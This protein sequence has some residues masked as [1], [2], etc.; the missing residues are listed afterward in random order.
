MATAHNNYYD[1][2]G[3]ATD[4]NL[5][6]VK[7]ALGRLRKK[8]SAGG[9]SATLNRIESILV[10]P[11]KR[12]KYDAQL[13]QSDDAFFAATELT[14]ADDAFVDLGEDAFM[15][16]SDLYLQQSDIEYA[17]SQDTSEQDIKFPVDTISLVK[18]VASG[19]LVA[20]LLV[21]A[22]IGFVRYQVH[23]QAVGAIAQ[24]E[25]AQA[26]VEQQIR[27]NGYFPS[28]LTGSV[29]QSEFYSL[30]LEQQKIVL[31]F[32]DNAAG[33]I[34]GSELYLQ[35]KHIPQLGLNWE[36]NAGAGFEQ[37]YLPAHCY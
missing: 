18:K 2:L 35:A 25:V 17:M 5:Q 10:D 34:R 22:Y 29:A 7:E 36:C 8:D 37:R 3:I 30:R 15:T 14:V 24:L 11:S 12:A 20:L 6:T 31:T 16:E 26:Q 9:L 19:A 13:G 27:S 21:G 1:M 33:P 28:T 23:E 4:A 32:N